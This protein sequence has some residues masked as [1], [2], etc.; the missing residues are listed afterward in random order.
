MNHRESEEEQIIEEHDSLIYSS[1]DSP[2]DQ[3]SSLDYF[4]KR[5]EE[6]R[7]VAK[8][9]KKTKKPNEWKQTKQVNRR[10]PNTKKKQREKGENERSVLLV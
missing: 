6:K 1:S 8:K 9:T 4:F 2:N 5:L 3:N 7:K 10:K